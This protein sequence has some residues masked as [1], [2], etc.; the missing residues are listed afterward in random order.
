[1]LLCGASLPNSHNSQ[2]ICRSYTQADGPA[3][4]L[5]LSSPCGQRLLLNGLLPLL[6]VVAALAWTLLRVLPAAA[7][8]LGYAP[9]PAHD[10]PLPTSTASSR[11]S[12]P[13]GGAR[14]AAA[15]H[16][17]HDHD[18]DNHD[19]A[20]LHEKSIAKSLART[21]LLKPLLAGLL[22]GQAV[23]AAAILA[24]LASITNTQ[25]V[26]DLVSAFPGQTLAIAFWL[27]AL[28]L[29]AIGLA[30][31]AWASPARSAD[32][33]SSPGKPAYRAL[34]WIALFVLATAP[35]NL[36]LLWIECEASSLALPQQ[37]QLVCDRP[38]V[39]SI[40]CSY[41]ITILI[42]GGT[43]SLMNEHR[44]R[45]WLISNDKSSKERTAS[46]W[47]YLTFS[48]FDDII[49]LGYDKPLDPED[50]DHLIAEDRSQN[51]NAAFAASRKAHWSLLPNLLWF[52]RHLLVLQSS[53]ALITV[54][55]SV[56]SPY[57]LR[58]ILN[59]VQDPST[60]SHPS[61]AILYAF[62][63][64]AAAVVRSMTDGQMYFLGRRIGLR[65]RSVILL[66]LF[67]KSLKPLTRKSLDGDTESQHDDK[68][69]A[70]QVV[71]LMSFDAVRILEVSSYLMYL[72]STPMQAILCIAYL[73]VVAGVPGLA[74]VIV[75]ALMI[76]A[77]SRIGKLVAACQKELMKA[78]DMRMSAI[79]ELLQ[80]IRIIKFFAWEPR[81]NDKIGKLRENEL[82]KLWTYVFTLASMRIV[83]SAAP[84]LVS[85]LTFTSMTLL[86]GQTLD[87]ATA[88]TALSIFNVL[89]MPLQTFPDTI[90]KVT[91]A[92]VSLGRI[93]AYLGKEEI[94]DSTD[95]HPENAGVVQ[96]TKNASFSWYEPPTD[97]HLDT[98]VTELHNITLKFPHGGLTVICGP[99]GGGKSSLLMA[100]L[101][102]LHAVSGGVHLGQLQLSSG[103]LPIAFASQQVWLQNATI[104][105]N[106]CFGTPFDQA[107]YDA[108]LRACALV[109]DLQNLDG[110]DM[111]EVGEKGVNLSGGQK[112]RISLARAVYSPSP[113][114]LMDDPL[115]AVDAPTAKHLFEKCI[116]GP[117]LAGR[118]RILVTHAEA[119]CAPSADF[120]VHIAQGS[121][122]SAVVNQ[123]KLV[124]LA[125]D[126][127]PSGSSSSSMR[128]RGAATAATLK[129]S[130]LSGAVSV[131]SDDS[132]AEQPA[133]V[134]NVK[135]ITIDE[136]RSRGSVSLGVYLA[137]GKAAGG[138]LFVLLVVLCY[139]GGQ[140]LFIGNDW[141]LK[142][143][144]DAY[145]HVASVASVA[146]TRL[147]TL[148]GST[149]A[150]GDSLFST[151]RLESKPGAVDAP[152][153]PVN[154]TYYV[155]I[156][157]LLGF[158]TIAALFLRVWFFEKTPVGRILN[159]FSKDIKDIDQEVGFFTGDF[160]GCLISTTVT[161]LLIIVV[162]PSTIFGIAPVAAVYVGIGLQYLR[163][164]RE[165]K[166][167]DSTTRSPI[168]SHFGETINGAATIRAY[169][170]QDQFVSEAY[171]RID[172]NHLAFFHLWISN[173]WLG[174]RIDFSG[175]LVTLESSI[176]I[177]SAVLFEGGI[178][179]GLAGLS[180]SYAMAFSDSLLWLIRMHALMEMEINAVERVQEYLA[181]EEEA[182]AVIPESRPPSSWPASG[183]IVVSNLTL[184][185]T[186]ESP[187]VL[188]NVSFN[189][190]PGEKIAIVGRT[191][192]GKTSLSLAFFRFLEH[193][194]GRI[195]IDG[196]DISRIGLH[197]LRSRITIIPQDPV[198]F[199]GTLR[200]NLDPFGECTDQAIWA[201][202]KQ[203]H[204]IES[205]DSDGTAST[206]G[207]QSRSQSRSPTRSASPARGPR[208]GSPTS[209]AERLISV[210]SY[211]AEGGANFSQGQRQLL[212]LARALLRRCRL[213][214][215]DEAT[216]SVDHAT[217][218]R[219]Q[220]TIREAFADATVLCIAHRLRTVIDM[221]KVLVLD[222]G[223]VAEFGSPAELIRSENGL[224]RGMCME[225]GEFEVLVEMAEA[226]AAARAASASASVV[227]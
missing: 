14:D 210:D 217:D 187:P 78:T 169:A 207:S 25:T 155:G 65:I 95:N 82:S 132:T 216:A 2:H 136:A 48:W 137:Y 18:H 89:R 71:N 117:L 45:V 99:T 76:P 80:G 167:L 110:G 62:I 176:A 16:N 81:F 202:L 133:V 26:Q 34:V 134:A 54:V 131:A 28:L 4:W 152:R 214:I 46:L 113:V 8:R 66:A 165:L 79:N 37:Q 74:G 154:L 17:D 50:L 166:R 94:P 31:D 44:L 218:A 227:P 119:L 97:V 179:P 150:L 102:E 186:P 211:V 49:A 35:S 53:F 168:F 104:R 194:A 195:V 206:D 178:N 220:Q 24:D 163:S 116:C 118:T 142:T 91:D 41:V 143:W 121:V 77:G 103:H 56:A 42:M 159:R 57:F 135:R 23:L 120:V 224:F 15:A 177:V 9:L 92:L 212:C 122:V 124:D 138:V 197:D 39:I 145:R 101:G 209:P 61:I 174:I 87:A 190:R 20:V 33:A 115:S 222:R 88:F 107:R 129:P 63:I 139:F 226:A 58:Q 13:V 55:L 141:W 69:M 148:Q 64:F 6:L 183:E 180:L 106:I 144:A 60:L 191:G 67:K 175:A 199:S 1:M 173:R 193:D 19:G 51:I 189:A 126:M 43:T 90:V 160:L 170:A 184:K 185:Y 188:R 12:V 59:F 219:I 203:S 192:A 157:A 140:M 10:S 3:L 40:L 204:V 200:S 73:Y 158:S 213:I 52:T 182:P 86:A 100:L 147:L 201:S 112:A 7:A 72:W 32:P 111:T 83:W 205:L 29:F 96:F 98:L 22:L 84:I 208:P 153:P 5:L 70:G 114:V 128:T 109:K 75:M 198:L 27:H 156:Y 30:L 68:V 125:P 85:F 225:T 171:K 127:T 123:A 162:T 196:V 105:E 172:H 108:T 223:H 130:P 215:L 181:I 221:D 161:L 36:R 149:A 38:R 164:S 47:S 151:M 93:E 11:A 21:A 146:S